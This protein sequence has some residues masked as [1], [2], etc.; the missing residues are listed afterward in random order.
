MGEPTGRQFLRL[1][2]SHVREQV[3][4]DGIAKLGEI[5]RLCARN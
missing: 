5:L 3:I 2:Y 1:A 4:A